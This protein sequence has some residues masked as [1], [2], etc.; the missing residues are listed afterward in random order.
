MAEW[1]E[2][3]LPTRPPGVPE[4]IPGYGEAVLQ[5]PSLPVAPEPLPTPP[6]PEIAGV[7]SLP[8]LPPESALGQLRGEPPPIAPGVVQPLEATAPLASLERQV[9][10]PA[11]QTREEREAERLQAAREAIGYERAV[12]APDAPL[13]ERVAVERVGVGAEAAAQALAARQRA[14]DE[15]KRLDELEAKRAADE[16]ARMAEA[17]KRAAEK[18]SEY[19]ETLKKSGSWSGGQVAGMIGAVLADALAVALQ[20]TGQ[21]RSALP[22]ILDT[23]LRTNQA[24][25]DNQVKAALDAASEGQDEIDRIVSRE[26]EAQR[27]YQIQ[28]AAV[29]EALAEELD[30]VAAK[31]IGQEQAIMARNAA[32]MAR[33]ESA[34]AQAAAAREDYKLETDRLGKVADVQYKA[35]QLELRGQEL[36]QREI[37]SRREAGLRRQELKIRA[38]GEARQQRK[39]EIDLALAEQKYSREEAEA[40]RKEGVLGFDNVV[41]KAGTEKRAD[42]LQGLRT[43][44]EQA[45]N[46]IDKIQGFRGPRITDWSEEAQRSLANYGELLLRMKEVYNLGVITGPDLELIQN[47]I[48]QEPGKVTEETLKKVF[49]RMDETRA[50][51]VDAVNTRFK[52]VPNYKGPSWSPPRPEKLG[53]TIKLD[54]EWLSQAQTRVFEASGRPADPETRMAA[55]KGLRENYRTRGKAS[56]EQVRAFKQRL[57][58]LQESEEDA[59][60]A[61]KSSISPERRAFIEAS[62]REERTA[63][64]QF[65]LDLADATPEQIRAQKDFLRE[66][67]RYR[68]SLPRD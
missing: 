38:A 33:A 59:L 65:Q 13:G 61:M 3:Y 41:F 68:R 34:A 24:T 2:A 35:G 21:Q 10:P 20:P 47:V 67:T 62:P 36:R 22:A 31:A 42:E 40:I 5:P 50:N 44:A 32:E 9:T 11:P 18:R 60:E 26:R 30:L 4:E 45:V 39:D 16:Q 58:Q 23:F 57:F 17:E 28:R 54:E 37:E 46:L 12:V 52:N 7:P 66:L 15:R 48:G 43:Q 25:W 6:L 1:W 29:S 51:I 56:K 53:Q 49:A 55:V 64:E 19:R 8:P 27:Q 14:A 63:V